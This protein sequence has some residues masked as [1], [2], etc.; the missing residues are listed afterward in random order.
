MQAAPCLDRPSFETALIARLVKSD[1][2]NAASAERAAR[3]RSETG[4]HVESLW[5]RR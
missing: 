3:V 4:E 2:I 1:K 5:W